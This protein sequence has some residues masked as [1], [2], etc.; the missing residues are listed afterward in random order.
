MLT[1]VDWFVA[2][3]LEMVCFPVRKDM[4]ARLGGAPRGKG[5]R[6]A[7]DVGRGGGS[8]PDMALMAV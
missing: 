7:P 8:G 4:G 1:C 3:A 2:G 6:G 5:W